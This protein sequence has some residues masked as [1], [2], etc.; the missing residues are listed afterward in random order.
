V[1]ISLAGFAIILVMSFIGIPLAYATLA[2]GFVGFWIV[3]GDISGALILSGQQIFDFSTLFGLSVVPLFILMGTLIQRANISDELFE[4]GYAWVGRYKGGLAMATVLSCAG[5]SAVSGSSLATAATMARVAM[6]P[7]RRYNY[8]DSLAAGTLAAGGTLGI[9][10][11]PSVPMVIYGIVTETN[12][13]FMFIAGIIPGILLTLCYLAA[14]YIRV[15]ITPELG[16]PGDAVSRDEKMR[17]LYKT[18]PI[19]VLFMLVLGGIYLSVFTPTEAGAVGCVGAFLFALSRGRMWNIGEIVE[20]AAD[21]VVITARI[22]LIGG[23]ALLFGQFLNF[24]GLSGALVEFTDSF[25]LGPF[26]LPLVICVICV[27]LGMIFESIGILFLI[28]PVFLPSLEAVAGQAGMDPDFYLI[29]FG[30]IV[31]IVVEL[32]LIT[33]PIGINV[34]TVKSVIP[35]VELTQI[36][37]G[38]M[39]FVV[40]DLVVLALIFLIPGL[41]IFLPSVMPSF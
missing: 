30:I 12:I 5:F 1:L 28:V 13:G 23:A 21:A 18:W 17:T 7:M 6:P 25:N 10:I 11:P 33:P 14:V 22:F 4:A 34:F 9:M 16:P 24:A 39:P 40:A 8:K 26:T 20:V 38:V 37:I 27:F 41:A 29:W 36:F 2:V 15:W 35:D 3:R 31:I 19:L 32:G